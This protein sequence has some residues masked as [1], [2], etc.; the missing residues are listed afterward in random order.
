MPGKGV[1]LASVKAIV[2][3][4]QGSIWVESTLGQGTT[5]RFTVNGQF[6]A[7]PVPLTDR[8]AA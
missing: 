8:R 7:A 4:Y 6:V 2:E 5:F 3:S 1:G